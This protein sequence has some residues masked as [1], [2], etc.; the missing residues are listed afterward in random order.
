VN[1]R[2]QVK[3]V[4]SDQE[5][6]EGAVANVPGNYF[7]KHGSGSAIVR[8]MMR[9]FHCL[10][11]EQILAAGARSVLDVGCGEG[12]TS[13]WIRVKAGIPVV[14]VELEYAPLLE[15]AA[16]HPNLPTVR[17]SAYELPF[18]SGAFD[19][20]MA[21]E[22]LEHLDDPVVAVT[23]LARVAS[24]WCLV[25]VPNEPWWRIANMAR[26]AYISDFGN[27]PGHVQ[28][29]TRRSLERFLRETFD[30][31]TITR[32]AMWNVAMCRSKQD[33]P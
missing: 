20:T 18:S 33:T 12:H 10:L 19:L 5:L 11:L 21:T 26:G 1:R 15:A 30:E 13:D 17:A 16:V 25:T 3:V 7:D 22:V 31:V 23:E 6:S 29:W 8:R 27:T 14:G 9:R 4:R 2:R 28:H 24:R 32:A